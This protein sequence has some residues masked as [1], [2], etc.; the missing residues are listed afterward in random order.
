[1][2]RPPDVNQNLKA[3]VFLCHNQRIWSGAFERE[4]REKNI[5][6]EEEEQEEESIDVE[7]EE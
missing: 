6:E 4:E 3:L 5:E 1:M 7:G 2:R